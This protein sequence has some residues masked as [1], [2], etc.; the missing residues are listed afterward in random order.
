MIL[1][2]RGIASDAAIPPGR[3]GDRLWTAS[4]A[5]HGDGRRAPPPPTADLTRAPNPI[6]LPTMRIG[7]FFLNIYIY[8]CIYIYIYMCM[9]IYIYVC[10]YIYVYIYIYHSI[11]HKNPDAGD[12]LSLTP[13]WFGQLKDLP[14]PAFM[15]TCFSFDPSLIIPN[16]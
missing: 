6:N 11:T 8:V 5:T 16:P 4:R 3:G 7:Y 9:Y 13:F 1:M 10:I 12:G 15:W 14:I 2:T